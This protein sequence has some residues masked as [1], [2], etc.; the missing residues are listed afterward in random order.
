MGGRDFS[1]LLPGARSVS[2]EELARQQGVQPV[3]SLDDMRA[4]V[5]DS[6]EELDEFLAD[7]RASRQAGL[8]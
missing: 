5:W 8:A 3:E 4:D 7:V 1:K 2:V 6:D